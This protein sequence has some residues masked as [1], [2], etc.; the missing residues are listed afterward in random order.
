MMPDAMMQDWWALI[1]VNF[2]PKQEIEPMMGV[3]TLSR[4]DIPFVTVGVPVEN[5][6]GNK[7]RQRVVIPRPQGTRVWLY[8]LK[9]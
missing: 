1:Q 7:R 5:L 3:G 9:A 6:C 4:A 8:E 2:D